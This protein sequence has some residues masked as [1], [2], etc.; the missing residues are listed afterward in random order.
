MPAKAPN[1]SGQ[2]ACLRAWTFAHRAVARCLIGT[3]HGLSDLV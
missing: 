3:D 1:P 2:S